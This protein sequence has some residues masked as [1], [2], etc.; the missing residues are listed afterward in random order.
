MRICCPSTANPTH[1]PGGM[2]GM[3]GNTGTRA[4]VMTRPATSRM[5]F[6]CAAL[7]NTGALASTPMMRASGNMKAVI[8]ASSC[9][10]VKAIM[11]GRGV[12]R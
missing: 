8:Q 3:G 4:M 10:L 9:A 11:G 2:A 6:G 1:E 5:R 12:S 7:L